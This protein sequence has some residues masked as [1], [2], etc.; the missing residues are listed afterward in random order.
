LDSVVIDVADSHGRPK[1][2]RISRE[3]LLTYPRSTIHD[4]L[5]NCGIAQRVEAAP[6]S[7]SIKT[8]S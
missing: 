6:Y 3:F 2:L 8:M 4:Y 1:E 7:V 5:K